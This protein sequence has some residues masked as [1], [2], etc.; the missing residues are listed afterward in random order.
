MFININ[1]KTFNALYIQSLEPENVTIEGLTV[2]NI[3]YKLQNGSVIIESFSTAEE[4]DEKFNSVINL[5]I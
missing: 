1:D 2:Y 5:S 4:R 3:N